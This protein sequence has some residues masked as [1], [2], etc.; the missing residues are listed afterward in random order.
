[1]KKIICLTFFAS[2]L[3]LSCEKQYVYT[4]EQLPDEDEILLVI[5]DG[6]DTRVTTKVAEVSQGPSTL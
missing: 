3:L 1:M 5:K 6:L 2:A 4:P